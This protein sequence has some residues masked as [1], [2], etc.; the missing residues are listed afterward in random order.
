MVSLRMQGA[1]ATKAT[2]GRGRFGTRGQALQS[3]HPRVSGCIQDWEHT[4]HLGACGAPTYLQG[5]TQGEWILAECLGRNVIVCILG[6][7]HGGT[8][9]GQ[10]REESCLLILLKSSY[11]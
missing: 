2:R 3:F 11:I 6:Y 9:P 8:L 1:E 10:K 5:V 7:V 4:K